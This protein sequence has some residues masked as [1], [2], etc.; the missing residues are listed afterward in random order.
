MN[1][2]IFSTLICL[3]LSPQMSFTIISIYIKLNSCFLNVLCHYNFIFSPC[4]DPKTCGLF[5]I[6]AATWPC[7]YSLY[8]T[9]LQIFLSSVISHLRLST[10][11]PNCL[12][13]KSFLTE[14]LI[15]FISSFT[16]HRNLTQNYNLMIFEGFFKTWKTKILGESH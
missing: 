8:T 4:T 1:S 11:L 7:A 9:L 5:F 12:P 10:F 14:I 15:I 16:C 13:V 3:A 6:K 2:D